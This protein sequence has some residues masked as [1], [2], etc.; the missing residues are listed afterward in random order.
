MRILNS[1]TNCEKMIGQKNNN[2]ECFLRFK[3]VVLIIILF[4]CYDYTL[5]GL[6]TAII[7]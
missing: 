1:R 2:S 4:F 3:I 5:V 7:Y 6:E